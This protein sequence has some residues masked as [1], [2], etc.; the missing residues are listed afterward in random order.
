MDNPKT[1]LK[2]YDLH[3]VKKFGQNFLVD[4][5]IIIKIAKT[6]NCTN[7]DG[8]LEIGPGLGHLTNELVN[9]AQKVV[10]IEIDKKLIPVLHSQLSK[11]DNLLIVNEDFLKL[12][13]RKIITNE[14]KNIQN[15]H[16]V[17]N[18]PYYITSQIVLKLLENVDLFTSFTLTMQKE[19]AQRFCSK[20]KT[21]EYSNLSIMCQF[22]CDVKIA[23]EISPASFTP[24][25]NVVSSVVY[26]KVNPKMKLEQPV[27]FWKF[28]R[29]C[30]TNKR[31]TLA[32]NVGVYLNDKEKAVNFINDLSWPS[33]IRAEELDFPMFYELFNVIN[34]N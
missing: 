26:F 28:V 24:I 11:H 6:S 19:V 1:L 22:Y 27:V 16:V 14:F 12:D 7:T 15:I 4:N 30:F 32:N 8:I 21:K 3:A 33:T 9:H 34:K 18:L 29:S 31:K 13:L 23:F 25:P 5:N 20:P 10:T 2:K 17:A